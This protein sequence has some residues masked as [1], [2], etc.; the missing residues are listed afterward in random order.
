MSS[1]WS[2]C[3]F[4]RIASSIPFEKLLPGYGL[5]RDPERTPMRWDHTPNAGFSEG[6]PWLP[7]GANLRE[8]NVSALKEDERSLLWLY[9]GLVALRRSES[10]LTAGQYV[11]ERSHNEL[12]IYRRVAGDECVLIALNLLPE[13]RRLQF[14]GRADILLST[15]LD[16][17]HGD[18]ILGPLILR[19]DEGLA[20]KV[21]K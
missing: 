21:R 16:Q 8:R 3:R 14:N 5:N 10:A 17:F 11:P 19:P 9:K 4:R 1:A 2:K 12:L 18:T 20:I 7:M 15:H 13:P 6:E